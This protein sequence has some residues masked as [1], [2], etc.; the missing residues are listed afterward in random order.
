[1]RMHDTEFGNAA[2]LNDRS[3]MT[4]NQILVNGK[5]KN[6]HQKYVVVTCASGHVLCNSVSG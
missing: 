3:K 4:Y 2:R 1:M 6:L 5:T